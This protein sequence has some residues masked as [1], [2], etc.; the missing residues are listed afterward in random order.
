MRKE[1][2]V[3]L[4][5]KKF[6]EKIIS[7]EK[8]EEVK[9]AFENEGIYITDQ[10]LKEIGETLYSVLEK[11]SKLSDNE[12]KKISGGII[13][14]LAVTTAGASAA[15]YYLGPPIINAISNISRGFIDNDTQSKALQTA[16]V[17][18]KTKELETSFKGIISQNPG[19]A[20]GAVGVL[21][22]S[23]AC[24]ISSIVNGRLKRWFKAPEN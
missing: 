6:M 8:P 16:M 13:G 9:E 4:E 17:Q 3:Q 14:T 18:Q 24:L 1:I 15:V 19:Y 5:K 10:E 20:A 22:L 23:A 2:L 11:I 21:G 7:M 12:I